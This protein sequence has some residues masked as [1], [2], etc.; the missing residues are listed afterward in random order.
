[1]MIQLTVTIHQF[2]Q[3]GEKTGWTYIEIPADAAQKLK[4]GNKKSFRVKGKLDS[5][6]IKGVALLPMGGG[7]FIMAFNGAMRKGTGKR[8]GA[9]LKIQLE[10]DSKAYQLNAELMECLNDEPR[11]LSFFKTLAKSH[12]NY[13]S[14]WVESAKTEATRTKRIAQTVT[15]MSKHQGFTEMM[16]SFRNDMEQLGQ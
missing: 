11:A 16:R 9:M 1:M 12:Q 5:Y 3:Q 13:F 6:L 14:K 4:P 2:A 15:A 7:K 8:K 10:T